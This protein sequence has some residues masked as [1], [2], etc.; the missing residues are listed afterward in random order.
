MSP[1]SLS[2]FVWSLQDSQMLLVIFLMRFGRLLMPCR[3]PISATPSVGGDYVCGYHSNLDPYSLLIY[4][5]LYMALVRQLVLM[6]VL[7]LQY[8]KLLTFYCLVSYS[9]MQVVPTDFGCRYKDFVN[10]GI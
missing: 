6:P 3:S 2:H 5:E 7:L 1:F 8:P 10:Q 4:L 9:K